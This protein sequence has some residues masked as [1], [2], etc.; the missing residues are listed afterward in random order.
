MSSERPLR[1]AIV[2]P[3]WFEIPPDAYGGI[4]DMVATLANGLMERGHDVTLVA[5][6]ED[7]TA[8]RFAPTFSSP[9]S[10]L[11]GPNT[12]AIELTHAQLTNELLRNLD[13]DVIH[14]HS[15]IGPLFAPYRHAPTVM[16]VHGP[17]EGWMHRV[18]RTL[19]S[20]SLVSISRAQQAWAPELPWAATVYNGIDVGSFPL[21]EDKDD[22]LV[23]LGRMN[24]DK[25]AREAVEL[26]RRVGRRLVL[27]AKC[28][29]EAELKYFE[30]EVRPRL[31]RGADFIGDVNAAQKRELLGRAAAL[32]FPIQWE[33]PFGLVMVEAMACGTPVLA[34]RRGSVPEVVDDGVTG[35]IRD[36]VDGLV[37]AF[38]GI[39]ALDPARIRDQAFRR[40]DAPRMIDGYEAVYR[41][42][43]GT[44]R[45]TL[46]AEPVAARR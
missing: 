7:R 20:V 45:L 37:E 14:D 41:T 16:T 34:T 24:Q 18:Y 22:Y 3:P 21:V 13:V 11:G 42:V 19:R 46:E 5:A 8:A 1:V 29:E 4:E 25:G 23:F 40:F 15:A 44:G 32:V 17:V 9:P 35:F 12:M 43:S 27:A 33:E 26:A 10:G 30:E 39:D 2:A 6:G 28:N 31:G 36:D 38:E